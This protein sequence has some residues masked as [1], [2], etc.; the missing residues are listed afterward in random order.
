[1]ETL[2]LALRVVVALGAILAVI[3]FVQRKVTGAGAK[4]AGGTKSAVAGRFGASKKAITV[5]G[6]HRLGA[7]AS[8]TVVEIDG[9]KMVLGVT[10]HG[11]SVLE[12]APTPQPL[13]VAPA[14]A[15]IAHPEAIAPESDLTPVAASAVETRATADV[16]EPEP[17]DFAAVFR[18]ALEEAAE[19][20][21]LATVTATT[22]GR[23]KA[24]H[25]APRRR[26]RRVNIP[27]LAEQLLPHMTRT[28]AG[29]I[30][31]R[32]EAKPPAPIEAPPAS[33]RPVPVPQ[34][35]ATGALAAFL[36]NT[37]PDEKKPRDYSTASPL[38][39][40]LPVLRRAS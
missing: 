22:A 15:V 10:E 20:P 32:V 25:V 27:A 39:V 23:E 18:E 8:I 11:I 16:R 17:V 1:M 4:S 6:T 36:R 13:V 38:A 2:F 28:L 21:T 33:I 7:K 30:G 31:I 3:W 29:A 40:H 19:T 34:T 26:R 9:V 24:E 35:G 5:L 14:T 37:E 12:P